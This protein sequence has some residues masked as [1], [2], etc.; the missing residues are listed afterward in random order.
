MNRL[1]FLR[2]TQ[3]LAKKYFDR[4][5]TIDPNIEENHLIILII[6]CMR[7]AVKVCKISSLV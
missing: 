1:G 3:Y 2:S 4:F 5:I 6:S 7:I